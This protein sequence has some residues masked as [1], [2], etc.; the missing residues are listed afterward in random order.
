MLV[1]GIQPSDSDIYIYIFFLRFS[2]V[3]PYYKML[4]IV[5]CAIQWVLVVY[6]FYILS[7]PPHFP[8]GNYKFLF[9]VC[10]DSLF[11]IQTEL[12]QKTDMFQKQILV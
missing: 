5:P 6:L 4:N 10:T 3:I 1:S 2:S 12:N 8:F 7:F 11:L 9:Y